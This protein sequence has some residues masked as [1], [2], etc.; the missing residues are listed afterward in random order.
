MTLEERRL[1]TPQEAAREHRRQNGKEVFCLW[2][3]KEIGDW[4][5]CPCYRPR[6]MIK[7]DLDA[8]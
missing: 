2:C 8:P 3:S 4:K 1:M 7:G 6:E 5:D